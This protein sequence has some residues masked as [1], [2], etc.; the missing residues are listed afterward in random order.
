MLDDWTPGTATDKFEAAERVGFYEQEVDL[1]WGEV[2]WKLTEKW[3]AARAKDP[4]WAYDV[5][6]PLGITD[7]TINGFSKVNEELPET[8]G[9]VPTGVDKQTGKPTY[10][11]NFL[12]EQVPKA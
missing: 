6:A 10:K 2:A 11:S 12:T 5:L 4:A 1:A 9:K 8:L 7:S 3:K